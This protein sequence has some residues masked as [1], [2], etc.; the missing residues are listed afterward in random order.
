MDAKSDGY[1]KVKKIETEMAAMIEQH[2]LRLLEYGE[3][4]CFLVAGEIE[5][6]LALD[7]ADLLDKAKPIT[8]N[9]VKLDPEKLKARVDGCSHQTPSFTR[10][11]I[12]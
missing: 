12:G 11:W 6:V 8:P 5:E 10:S 3:V 2:D 7:D 4:V 1:P 9:R